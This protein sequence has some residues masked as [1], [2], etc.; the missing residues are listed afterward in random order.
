MTIYTVREDGFETDDIDTVVDH[1]ID[2]EY[3]RNDDIEDW[4]ND[5]YSSYNI[6]G[7]SYSAYDVLDRFDDLD[8]FVRE[9]CESLDESD[10]DEARWELRHA[11]EGDEVEIQSYTVVVRIEDDATATVPEHRPAESNMN[12][13][14]NLRQSVEQMR[15]QSEEAEKQDESMLQSYLDLFQAM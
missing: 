4:V 3:H 11:T 13:L 7:Y 15:S 14:E 10:A 2:G 9:Y 5:S 1:C 8:D 6:G 12:M